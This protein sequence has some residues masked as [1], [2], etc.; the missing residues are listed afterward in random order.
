[1]I[2]T[3]DHGQIAA[4]G[5]GRLNVGVLA[6][7]RSKRVAIFGSENICKSY[8]A[9]GIVDYRPFGMPTNMFPVFSCELDSFDLQD[10]HSVSHG[11][12]TIEEAIVPVIELKK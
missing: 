6:E 3:S 12:I 5:K 2:I 1:V 9:N 4:V 10:M 7:Q 8:A 11:G